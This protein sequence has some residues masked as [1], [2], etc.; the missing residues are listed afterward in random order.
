M[1]KNWEKEKTQSKL[2]L[3]L[4]KQ[5]FSCFKIIFIGNCLKYKHMDIIVLCKRFAFALLH[6]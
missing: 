2:F 4:Y 3:A 5:H 1:K 6:C